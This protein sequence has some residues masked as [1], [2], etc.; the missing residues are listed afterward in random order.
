MKVFSKDVDGNDFFLFFDYIVMDKLV[1]NFYVIDKYKKFVIVV[2]ISGNKRWEF[3]DEY[4]LKIFKGIVVLG[5]C[6]YV[7]GCKFYN[8][9]LMMMDGDVIGNVISDGIFNLYKIVFYFD[10][11]YFMVI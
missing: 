5:I 10:G 4:L 2:L 9:L 11:D 6:V 7:V 1:K 3:Y 8:V